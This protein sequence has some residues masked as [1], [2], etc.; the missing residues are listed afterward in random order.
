M[1]LTINKEEFL[2]GLVTAGHAI[3]AKSANPVLM[4]F[5]LEMTS[6]G[7]EIT[8]SDNDITVFT[9]VPLAIGETEIIRNAA[10]GAILLNARVL[11][12]LLKKIDSAEV[13]IE[14]VDGSVAK[15][16]D[17]KSEFK[18][19]CID[20]AQYPDVVLEESEN[21]FEL[22]AKTLTELVDQTSFAAPIK[23]SRPVLTGIFLKAAGGRL[24]ATAS[25]S[26]RLSRKCV[27]IPA[28]IAF[29]TN[30]PA[31]TL[32]TVVRMLEGYDKVRMSCFPDK[33]IFAFGS[34]LVSCSVLSG[35]YPINDHIIPTTFNYYL[36]TNALELLSAIERI[37]VL[38][39]DRAPVVKLTMTR[40]RVEV[41]TRSDAT[42]SGTECLENFQY[43][44]ERLEIS[45]NS[46]FVADAVKAVRGQDVIISF[47]GEMKPFMVKNPKDD[48]IIEV[49]TPMR[50]R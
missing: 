33:T 4:T 9:L 8:G 20:A 34:T 46:T 2:K 13:T 50:S 44:G 19:N 43:T 25:D 1:R 29:A 17:G 26:A 30:V 39:A 28:N 31:K 21:S 15:L 24:T 27:D 11:S 48:S 40:D 41:S 16:S 18:L 3:G 14:V 35:E 6:R 22:S 49:V 32:T 37:G 10:S 23:S 12:E 38:N 36:E 7:L 47:L 45:F 42:G 5:K